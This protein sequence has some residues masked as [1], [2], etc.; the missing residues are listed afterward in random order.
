[1]LAF[2]IGAAA[3]L[4]AL[5]LAS[6]QALARWR[7]SHVAGGKRAKITLGAVM[8]AL[9]LMIV[10]G[11]DRRLETALTDASPQWLADLTTRF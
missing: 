11:L 7:G 8:I 9:G 3:P 4:A 6:R 1:M 2:G 10:G 5:G